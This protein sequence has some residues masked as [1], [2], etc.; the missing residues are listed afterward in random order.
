MPTTSA[1]VTPRITNHS[2]GR[3]LVRF[4]TTDPRWYREAIPLAD[5]RFTQ[6]LIELDAEESKKR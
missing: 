3:T 2:S 5:E 6:H 4:A 1:I